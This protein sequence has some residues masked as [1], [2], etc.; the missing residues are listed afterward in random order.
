VTRLANRVSGE[1]LVNAGVAINLAGGAAVLLLVLSGAHTPLSLV[2][3][4]SLSTFSIGLIFGAAPMLLLDEA[5]EER[6]GIASGLLG[7]FE[8]GMASV[9]AFAVGMLYN[10]T[11][12]PFAWVTMASAF[13]G[14]VAWWGLR[15][16]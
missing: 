13:V 4:L 3:V 6:R 8:I 15:G 12:N 7:F 2:A 11:A 10:G 14:A 9:G 16:R 5:G 1:R